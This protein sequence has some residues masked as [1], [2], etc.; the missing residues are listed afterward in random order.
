[1]LIKTHVQR[2]R[3][4]SSPRGPVATNG[5]ARTRPTARGATTQPGAGPCKMAQLLGVEL[6]EPSDLEA[7][8]DESAASAISLARAESA[9]AQGAADKARPAFSATLAVRPPEV[10]DPTEAC[11]AHTVANSRPCV[12]P[13]SLALSARM[14]ATRKILAAHPYPAREEAELAALTDEHTRCLVFDV[15]GEPRSPATSVCEFSVFCGARDMLEVEAA[16]RE[17]QACWVIARGQGC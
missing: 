6:I 12:C 16:R 4:N 1:M 15:L 10:T 9:T 7:L 3:T 17:A 8:A 5:R 11:A 13:M 14:A 2:G